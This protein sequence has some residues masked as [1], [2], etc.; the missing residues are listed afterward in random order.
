MTP[1]F[2]FF[3]NSLISGD[4]LIE[5]RNQRGNRF[6]SCKHMAETQSATILVFAHM[7]R[8]RVPKVLSCLWRVSGFTAVNVLPCRSDGQSRKKCSGGA[9]TDRVCQGSHILCGTFVKTVCHLRLFGLFGCLIIIFG[10][11]CFILQKA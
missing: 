4:T 9:G 2:L 6:P 11:G 1:S 7:Q 8:S 10:Q 3:V 5:F